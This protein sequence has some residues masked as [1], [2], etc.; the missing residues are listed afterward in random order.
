MVDREVG[1]DTLVGVHALGGGDECG[2]PVLLVRQGE[3]LHGLR[4][5][6]VV[7]VH[8]TAMRRLVRVEH[9]R[10]LLEVQGWAQAVPEDE[11]R[12]AA[13]A[14]AAHDPDEALFDALENYGRPDAPGCC[15]WTWS[16]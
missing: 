14:V 10:G 15:D 1:R 9:P 12:A 3:S 2:R 7:A 13:V 5:D 11:A 16:R 4:D 8:L 6:A